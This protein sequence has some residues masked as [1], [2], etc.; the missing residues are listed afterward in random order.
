MTICPLRQPVRAATSPIGGGI[1]LSVSLIGCHLPHGGEAMA[2]PL[3]ELSPQATERANTQF[4][5][6]F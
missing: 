4:I 2:L 1:A 3:G 6:R 5:P